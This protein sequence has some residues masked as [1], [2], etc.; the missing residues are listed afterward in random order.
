MLFPLLNP[1]VSY[2]L[3]T[4]KRVGC[5]QIRRPVLDSGPQQGAKLSQ[6]SADQ[7]PCKAQHSTV[8]LPVMLHASL[9]EAG[10]WHVLSPRAARPSRALCQREGLILI[11]PELPGDSLMR[12][13]AN[14]RSFRSALLNSSGRRRL[15]TPLLFPLFR[16]VLLM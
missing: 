9:R 2:R 14:T 12:D 16:F 10:L 3:P 8:D 6:G 15:F 5:L 13:N 7:T 11:L 1:R 4:T